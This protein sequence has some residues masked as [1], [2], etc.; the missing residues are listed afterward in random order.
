MD[1]SISSFFGLA[2][3]DDCKNSIQRFADY[4]GD[5]FLADAVSIANSP[6]QEGA[7]G[8]LFIGF[9]IH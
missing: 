5:R 6:V 7:T 1:G 3:E 2:K 9:I 4:C 8:Q